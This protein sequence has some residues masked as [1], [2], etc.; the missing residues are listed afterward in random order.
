MIQ[1][2]P[3]SYRLKFRQSLP[4]ITGTIC[5]LVIVTYFAYK[6]AEEVIIETAEGQLQQFSSS[7]NRQDDYNLQWIMRSLPPLIDS[8][9]DLRAASPENKHLEE[10]KLIEAISDARGDQFVEIISL[11]GDTLFKEVFSSTRKLYSAKSTTCPTGIEKGIITT[12]IGD[13]NYWTA[14]NIRN[15]DFEQK[16]AL[17]IGSDRTLNLLIIHVLK[18]N[19]QETTGLLLVSLSLNWYA[20]RIKSFS[21]FKECIP[22][23]LTDDSKWTL[24][25]GSSKQ[26]GSLKEIILENKNG[27]TNVNWHKTS[28]TCLFMPSANNT[29]YI[30]VLIPSAD[31]FSDLNTTTLLLV[32][33]GFLVLSL[34]I[35]GLHKT[36][37]A[38]LDP[39]QPVAKMAQNLAHGNFD[40]VGKISPDKISTY[41]TEQEELCIAAERLN[42]ALKQRVQDLTLMATTQERIFGE[43]A[44]ARSIQDGLKPLELPQLEDLEIAV[45]VHTANEVYGDM[46][47]CFSLSPTKI[48]TMIGSVAEHGIPAA[49]LSGKVLPL[50]HELVQFGYSPE[51]V[52]EEANFSFEN[53]NSPASPFISVFI[54]ILDTE[55]G[56]LTFANAG[57]E[58]P[59]IL[60][61]KD[62]KYEAFALSWS[63]NL[64]L[65][66][67]HDTK[68]SLHQIQLQRGDTLL[69]LSQ[70]FFMLQ[71]PNK[72]NYGE[73]NFRKFL[74]TIKGS[75]D[76]NICLDLL[77]KDAEKHVQGSLQEDITLLALYWKIYPLVY[78]A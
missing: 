26:L 58:P 45:K 46:Y 11:E 35:Y 21:F 22:F 2:I 30:G 50:L 47:D 66:I 64:P 29:Y 14:E 9:N 20:E 18:D 36:A 72:K 28:Y 51:K 6:Q 49:L 54:C 1:N 48:C 25:I 62:N 38:L 56:I 69:F 53:L 67:R 4:I 10:R 19:N 34:A 8:V 3:F 77:L 24:P 7:I 59:F 55:T 27:S 74:T 42:S 70:R 44:L 73:E 75:I 57:Q 52:L 15:L 13:D 65:G 16:T 33:G 60:Q 78:Q 68:Y 31:L 76:L 12:E 32:F 71:N 61:R 39:L 37:N 40:A 41:P 63:N 5:I 17:T 23:F 43:L